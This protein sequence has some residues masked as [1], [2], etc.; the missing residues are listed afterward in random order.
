MA[1]DGGS[2]KRSLPDWMVAED[3]RQTTKAKYVPAKDLPEREKP[4]PIQVKNLNG[5]VV[6][7]DVE[8]TG[9][10]TSSN[11]IIEVGAVQISNGVLTGVSFLKQIDPGEEFYSKLGPSLKNGITREQLEQGG[12]PKTTLFAFA[13]FLSHADLL[14]A[15][16]SSFDISFLATEC[17]RHSIS[18]PDVPTLCTQKVFLTLPNHNGSTLCDALSWYGLEHNRRFG[19]TH[20]ALCDAEATAR[21]LLKLIKNGILEA[22]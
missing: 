5:R 2:K 8:T 1:N 7:L 17:H 16:N 15:H 9:F 11:R 20:N 3:G 19:E 22:Q 18:F 10:S 12:D 21:L 6:V 4:K 14:V 13:E